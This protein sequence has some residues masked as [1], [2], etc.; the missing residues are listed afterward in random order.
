VGVMS[1]K[2]RALLLAVQ[3]VFPNARHGFCQ[4]H[5]LDNAAEPVAAADEQMKIE[6]RQGV[7]AEVG[8]L[9]RQSSPKSRAY[10][11]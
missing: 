3:A 10:P 1:D 5:Y 7:R 9:I 2:Q 6:L 8:A 4:V 11:A